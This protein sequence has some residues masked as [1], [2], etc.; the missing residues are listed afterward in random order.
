MRSVFCGKH[1]ISALLL[2]L[3]AFPYLCAQES[4]P[5]PMTSQPDSD[6]SQAAR[7]A[8]AEREKQR[9]LESTNSN[10][11]NQMAQELAEKT[12][13]AGNAPVGY[14]YY[15]AD[16]GEYSILVPEHAELQARGDDGVTLLSSGEWGPTTEVILGAPIAPHGGSTSIILHN[17]ANDYFS[18]CNVGGSVRPVNG[19]PAIFTSFS[20][21][22]L[23]HSLLG[24]A[25]FVLADGYIVPLVCGYPLSAEDLT[26]NTVQPGKVYTKK[27]VDAW[28]KKY[29]RQRL[30]MQACQVV[31]DSLQFRPHGADWHPK[32]LVQTPEKAVVTNALLT[33]SP[34]QAGNAS[35]GDLA[36]AQRKKAVVKPVVE[37]L[38]RPGAVGL[39]PYSFTYCREKECHEASILVPVQAT[40]S[41]A[42]ERYQFSIPVQDTKAVIEVGVGGSSDSQIM[43]RDQ[44]AKSP[45]WPV[46]VAPA[47]YD[48]VPGT[49]ET[50]GKEETEL[51]NNP[52]RI[53]TFRVATP[54]GVLM[55]KQATVLAPARYLFIRCSSPERVF[56]DIQPTCETVIRSLEI[57]QPPAEDDP[58]QS[59]DEQ[60]PQP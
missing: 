43:D 53:F 35:L 11:V 44:I 7:K 56:A 19:H 57:P 47:G 18:D 34:D 16:D 36:R 55:G 2:V 32:T 24:Q 6:L 8:K 31:F 12:E 41:A 28:Q 54:L 51:A 29:D 21:C 33:S 42:G 13:P 27:A 5:L 58:P 45:Y 38:K 20:G 22:S 10:A 39:Q 49:V 23:G 1:L 52:A 9:A 40:A 26:P 48:S 4:T 59:P 46:S 60:D 37:D 14:R 3:W 30:G 25:V 15:S 17:A 50:L